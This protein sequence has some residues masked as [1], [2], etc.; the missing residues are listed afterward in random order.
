MAIR[1]SRFRAG[2]R[3]H[4]RQPAARARLPPRT[5]LLADR[6]NRLSQLAAGN[7]VTRF[8]ELVDPARCRIWDGAQPRLR[9]PQPKRPA[10][11]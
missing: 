10:P 3:R 1:K 4:H 7:A 5:G 8:Q 2:A 6:E 11:I 9:G